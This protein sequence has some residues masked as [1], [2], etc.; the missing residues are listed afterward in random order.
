MVEI[1]Q[2]VKIHYKS[3]LESGEVFDNTFLRGEPVEF[4]V[5]SKTLLPGLESAVCDMQVGE[6]KTVFIPAIQAYGLYNENLIEAVPYDEIPNA[7]KLPVGKY[8]EVRTPKGNVRVKVAK[9]EDDLVYFD[10][11][12]ELAGK[13]IIVEVLLYSVENESAV[14]REMHPVGCGCG[15]DRLKKSLAK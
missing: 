5:G 7:D 11:N 9:I 3:S 14:E 15:C 10:Y 8:I 4:T 1:G 13:N 6:T 12:H 2:K